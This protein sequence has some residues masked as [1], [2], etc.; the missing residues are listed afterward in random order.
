V[1]DRFMSGMEASVVL[2]TEVGKTALAQRTCRGTSLSGGSSCWLCPLSFRLRRSAWGEVVGSLSAVG[3]WGWHFGSWR[4]GIEQRR[5]GM[6]SSVV[7]EG[8]WNQCMALQPGEPRAVVKT[9]YL[10]M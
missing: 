5:G 4:C 1:L 7:V 3:L 9:P 6:G 8:H 10:R 2:L